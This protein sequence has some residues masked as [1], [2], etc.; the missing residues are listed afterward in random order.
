MH[1]ALKQLNLHT[2]FSK[3]RSTVAQ[4][5]IVQLRPVFFQLNTLLHVHKYACHIYFY[6]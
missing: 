2:T 1:T 3:V 4:S 6:N 5:F